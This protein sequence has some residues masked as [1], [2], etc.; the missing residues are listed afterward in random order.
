MIR[1]GLVRTVELMP[2]SQQDA[3]RTYGRTGTGRNEWSESRTVKN[4]EEFDIAFVEEKD[5][6]ASSKC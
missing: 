6:R 4:H 5:E 3:I 1:D 2:K